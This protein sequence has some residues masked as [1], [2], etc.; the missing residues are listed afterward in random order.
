MTLILS[1]HMCGDSVYL[2]VQRYPDSWSAH[3]AILSARDY[4]SQFSVRAH[5]DSDSRQ[6]FGDSDSW[7]MHARRDSVSWHVCGG[8]LILGACA[9]PH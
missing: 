8:T 3:E 1:A 5:G 4:D 2:P 6:M 7:H 9:K